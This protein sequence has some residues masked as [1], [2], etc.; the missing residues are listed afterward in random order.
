MTSRELARRAGILVAIVLLATGAL[1]IVWGLEIT[2]WPFPDK[3]SLAA[4][5]V[6]VPEDQLPPAWTTVVLGL[7]IAA[8]G[9]VVLGRVARWSRR[10]PRWPFAVGVWVVGGLLLL[11]G[12]SGFLRSGVLVSVGGTS[13]A[14]W[15]AALYSPLSLLLGMM[16][17]FVAMSPRP[18]HSRKTRPERTRQAPPT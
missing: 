6:N 11:R 13:Y 12:V 4:T 16:C 17:V 3:A 8:G 5:V 14:H 18:R 10:F 1:E 2:T 15:D 7:L 9:I